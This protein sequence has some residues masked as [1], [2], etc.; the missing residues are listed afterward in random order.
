M[1]KS[2]PFLTI[3]DKNNL[4]FFENDIRPALIVEGKTDYV[5]YSR[6]FLFSTISK[7]F[8]VVVGESKNNI[9]Q[10]Y[11][12][13]KMNFKFLVLLDAD[14]DIFKNTCISDEKVI[15][16]H[17]Y[18]MEN[19]L[20]LK[21]VVEKTFFDLMSIDTPNYLCADLILKEV[22]EQIEP[23]VIMCLMKLKH[24]WN[25]K[26]EEFKMDRWIYRGEVQYDLLR[27]YCA[28]ELQ[29]IDVNLNENDFLKTYKNESICFT[30]IST[31]KKDCVIHGKRKLEILFYTFKKFFPYHFKHKNIDDFV[32][33]LLKNI[34]CSNLVRELIFNIDEQLKGYC[35]DA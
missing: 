1:N 16:T 18:S 11:N 10:Y 34:Q 22:M 19:Y 21:D 14:Y 28:K 9:L 33:D 29:S 6:I 27:D 8:D 32:L 20:T 24:N 2:I 23:F 13:N 25:I 17:Y 4:K 5:V 26:L 12:N 15:Y 31:E 3:E 30:N 7:K 35:M